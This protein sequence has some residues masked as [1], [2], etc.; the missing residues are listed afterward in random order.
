MVFSRFSVALPLPVCPLFLGIS[1]FLRG[2]N[3]AVR[4][5]ILTNAFKLLVAWIKEVM[6]EM[7]AKKIDS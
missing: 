1:A 2:E 6:A 3:F 7:P 4:E 5:I